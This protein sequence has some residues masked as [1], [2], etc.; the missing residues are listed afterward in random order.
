MTSILLIGTGRMAYHLGH[1]LNQAR[2][3]LIGVAGRD[4]E[5]LSDIARFLGC[6]PHRLDRALPPA[7][8]V[9][10]ATGPMTNLALALKLSATAG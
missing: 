8:L 2:L 7:D 1:A 3:P 4:A 5:K 9:I 10:I 6:A